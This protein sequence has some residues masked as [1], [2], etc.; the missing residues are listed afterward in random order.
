MIYN[1]VHKK[2]PQLWAFSVPRYNNPRMKV[3]EI[4]LENIVRTSE[5]LNERGSEHEKY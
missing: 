2:R 3:Q 1:E 4:K 5:N